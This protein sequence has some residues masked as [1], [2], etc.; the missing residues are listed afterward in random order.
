[1]GAG[2][3]F[4]SSGFKSEAL[5]LYQDRIT[6][7]VQ[8]QK[9]ILSRLLQFPMPTICVINGHAIAGGLIF[10]LCF[11][12]KIMKDQNAI[13]V[14]GELNLGLGFMPGYAAVIKHKLD[15]QTLRYMFYAKKYTAQM[16]KNS[17]VVDSLYKNDEDLGK[18]IRDYADK[19]NLQSFDGQ[20]YS[21]QKRQQNQQLL[22]ILDNVDGLSYETMVAVHDRYKL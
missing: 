22:R 10:G 1:M 11:D 19:M 12:H 9:S 2:T 4:F 16:C 20:Q 15:S 6:F 18:Q 21:A 7:P 5:A 13:A 3:K 14:L 17:N 8:F